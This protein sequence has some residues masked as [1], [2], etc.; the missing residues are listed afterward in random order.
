[1]ENITLRAE[2]RPR[3]TK[4]GLRALRNK[5]MLPA[6]VYGKEVGNLLVQCSEKEL[7]SIIA[8][9][10]IG[11]TLINLEVVNGSDQGKAPYLV[12]IREVQ[13]DPIKQ[14]LMHV[15]FYQVSLTEEI[16]TEIPVHLIGEA[17]GVKEGGVLQHLLREVTVSCLPSKLPERLE[18]D[19]SGLGIGDQLTVGD[20]ELPEGVKVLD[21]PDAI[22]VSVVAPVAEEPEAG[23]EAAEAAEAAPEPGEE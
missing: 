13:R 14:K 23:E 11:G 16:E 1:M 18:A 3:G 19:I 21:D 2:V 5:G 22:I 7:A 12:M 10:S 15:D 8:R 17:P 9:H 20:L 4:G 6:V